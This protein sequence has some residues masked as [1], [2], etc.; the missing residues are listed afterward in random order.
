MAICLRSSG[1]EDCVIVF[2]LYFESQVRFLFYLNAPFK[3]YSWLLFH[4]FLLLQHKGPW[5]AAF[6]IPDWQRLCYKR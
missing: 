3:Y 5:A 2:K 6:Y 1:G 4:Y